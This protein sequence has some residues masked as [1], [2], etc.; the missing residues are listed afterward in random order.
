MDWT[1]VK[2][3]LF[4][5]ALAGFLIAGIGVFINSFVVSAGGGIF[6]MVLLALWS[7]IRPAPV[8]TPDEADAFL[9][10][11]ADEEGRLAARREERERRPYRRF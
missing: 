11:K 10:G 5:A 8:W 4:Y 7:W 6:G 3:G 2:T 1:E 9:R